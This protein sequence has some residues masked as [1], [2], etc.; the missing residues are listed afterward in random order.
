MHEEFTIYSSDVNDYYY[1][2]ITFK[3]DSFKQLSE[4]N[5]S[6]SCIQRYS[7]VDNIFTNEQSIQSKTHTMCEIE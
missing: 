4:L 7:F 6:I 2:A 1:N 3:I 5:I